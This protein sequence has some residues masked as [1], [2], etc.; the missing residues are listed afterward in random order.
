ML[1]LA[2]IAGLS[3]NAQVTVWED[4]FE[5]YD[6]FAITGIGDYTQIDLD[7]DSTYGSTD[8]DFTNES[9]TGTG[10]IFNPSMTTPAATGTVWDVRTGNK[11]LYFFAAT[12]DV[13]GTPLNNDYFITPAIDLTGAGGGTTLSFWAQ[14]VT[15]QYGLER[16]EVLLSTTGTNVADFTEN[17]SGGE[18]QAPEAVYTEFSYDLTAYEGEQVYVAIHYVAQ[19]S[20]VL[21][22]DDFLVETTTLGVGENAFQ[23]FSHFVDN[24]G[25]LHLRAANQME[26]ITLYNVIGQQVLT[27]KLN[28]TT[29]TVNISELTSGVYIATVSIDGQNKSFKI[30]KR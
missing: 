17:L 20:F 10:I 21:Q 24:S 22:M 25:E 3:L 29:A 4:G 16:F 8:Y 13:S 9:Y 2:F 15:A 14:S 30:V 11:G 12:G 6:D 26:N 27:Q 5:S 18:E 1:A 7:G 23:G 28:N 19:D